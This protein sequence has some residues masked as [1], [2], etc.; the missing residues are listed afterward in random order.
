MCRLAFLTGLPGFATPFVMIAQNVPE[1]FMKSQT[2]ILSTLSK[3]R[4]LACRV[5]DSSSGRWDGGLY[6]ASV[7]LGGHGERAKCEISV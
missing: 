5:E 6:C 3:G 4:G 1:H 2:S 7:V